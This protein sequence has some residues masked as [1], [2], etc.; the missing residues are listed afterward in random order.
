MR[1][2][3]EG[4]PVTG[5]IHPPEIID[6]KE[7]EIGFLP[8][9]KTG[10]RRNRKKGC[11]NAKDFEKFASILYMPAVS[12]LHVLH[13]PGTFGSAGHDIDSFSH[14]SPF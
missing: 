10:T 8:P 7:N 12:I 1:R 2:L 13:L 5:H 11:T 3:V 14:P 9:E 4:T 6:E